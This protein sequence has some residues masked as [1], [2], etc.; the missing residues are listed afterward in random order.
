MVVVIDAIKTYLLQDF[1]DL[2]EFR[3]AFEIIEI[4]VVE[5]IFEVFWVIVVEENLFYFD[6]ACGFIGHRSLF[7]G[8]SAQIARFWVNFLMG[9]IGFVIRIQLKRKFFFASEDRVVD[10]VWVVGHRRRGNG[11][12]NFQKRG[13]ELEAGVYLFGIGLSNLTIDWLQLLEMGVEVK[14]SVNW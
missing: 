10:E 6:F 11:L 3:F 2:N 8:L 14:R 4:S 7:A 5:W 9:N 1:L 13:V 12:K